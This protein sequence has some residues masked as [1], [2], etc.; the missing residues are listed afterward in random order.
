MKIMQPETGYRYN[1][2]TMMLYGFICEEGVKGNVLEVGCGCGVLGLLLKRDFSA[3]SLDMLDIQDVNIKIAKRNAKENGIL[4]D[5]ITADFTEFSSVKKYDYIISNPPY[6]HNGAKKS[7]N[8]HLRVS[9]YSE[10]LPLLDFVKSANSMI[11]PSGALV[12]CYD[13]KQICQILTVLK[14]Y[15]FNPTRIKFVHPKAN[16]E[17]SLV[18]IEAKKS[19][20]ALSKISPPIFVFE[21]ERYTKEASEIF[22]RAN[23]FSKSCEI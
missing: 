21:G 13:A 18:M 10:N 19:S 4:A 20:K 17:A 15:K 12:F 3:I 5:F 23:T 7:Q 8:E 9:R 11:K 2:D 1:S 6:Y 22:A 16:K 14:S